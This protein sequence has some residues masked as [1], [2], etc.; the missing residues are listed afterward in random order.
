M[1]RVTIHIPN[2]LHAKLTEMSESNDDS[3]SATITKMAEIG[4]MVK[5]NSQ[6]NKSPEDRFSD[7]EKHCF[8]LTIQMNALI[9]NISVKTLNY[10]PDE[11]KKF[12]DAA[13]IK[14]RELLGMETEE[15]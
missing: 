4:I 13:S 15:L 7:L 6:K 3:L 11:F 9:K 8:K 5:E 14:Y 10:G 2:E 1:P 12:N